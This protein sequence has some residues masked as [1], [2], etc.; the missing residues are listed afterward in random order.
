MKLSVNGKDVEFTG[1]SLKELLLQLDVDEATVVA[2]VGGS[3]V[4]KEEFAD[5]VLSENEKV[6]LVRF[7][8]GG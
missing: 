1:S 4:P 5:K 6:E 7:V 8:P 2:E 3:I